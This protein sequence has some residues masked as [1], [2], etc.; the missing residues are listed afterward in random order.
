MKKETHSLATEEETVGSDSSV[1]S[2]TSSGNK[3]KSK[4]KKSKKP[5]KTSKK[6]EKKEQREVT[7]T[8][9]SEAVLRIYWEHQLQLHFCS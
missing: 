6:K 5:K 7:T 8:V 2:S 4:S 1:E 9:E 3:L